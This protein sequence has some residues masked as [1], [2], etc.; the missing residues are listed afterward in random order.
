MLRSSSSEDEDDN[1]REDFAGAYFGQYSGQTQNTTTPVPAPRNTYS[2]G[3]GSN[4]GYATKSDYSNSSGSPASTSRPPSFDNTKPMGGSSFDTVSIGSGLSVPQSNY[5]TKSH[6]GSIH[7]TPI[8]QYR[9]S[10]RSNSFRSDRGPQPIGRSASPTSSLMSEREREELIRINTE[11]ED[12]RRQL[13]IYVFVLRCIA[14][15]FNAK[16]KPPQATYKRHAK[17]SKQEHHRIKE[18]FRAFLKGEIEMLADDALRNAVQSYYEVFLKSDRVASM[19]KCGACS[20]NDFREV[21]KN[22]IE[23]RVRSLPAINGLSKETVLASW[24]T[25]FDAI[26]RGDEDESKR[27]QRSAAAANELILSK[28]QLYEMFQSIFDIKKYEHLILF[29]ALQLDNPDEQA[30]QVRRE[31]A[32]RQQQLDSHDF[33]TK[34]W[35]PQFLVKEMESM[36]ISELNSQI[37]TLK[38]N[39]ESV[40]VKAGGALPRRQKKGHHNHIDGVEESDLSLSKHDVVLSFTIEVVIQELRGLKLTGNKNVYCTMEVDGCDK[41]QT[42]LAPVSKPNWGT[43]GD[44]PTTQPLP[45]IKIKLYMENSGLLTI[46]DKELGKVTLKPTAT[47]SKNPQFYKLTTKNNTDD[48]HLRVAVRMDKPQNM[49]YCGYLYALGKRVWSTCKSRYFVLVQVSQCAFAV[50]RYKERKAEP[51][52]MLHLKGF[53]VDYCER[54]PEMDPNIP[55]AFNAVKEGDSV[56]FA[57][58]DENERHHW[59]QALYRATGQSHKPTPPTI[60]ANGTNTPNLPN[61]SKAQGEFERERN[62]G[63]DEFLSADPCNFNH[64]QLF[65]ILQRLTLEYRMNEA[66]TCLGWF[67]PGQ[68]YI[69]DEYVARYGVRGCHR[70]LC[71]TSD[72]LDQAENGLMIDPNIMHFAFAFSSAHVYGNKPDGLGTITTEERATFEVIRGRLQALLEH[73]IT[74]FRYSFPFGR[75]DG[76]LKATLSLL[77]KVLMKERSTQH[78]VDE[79]RTVI[80]KC[81]EEAALVNYTRI[82]EFA[83][84]EEGMAQDNLSERLEE[85]T[86]LAG[87]CIEVLQQNEEHHAEAFTWFDDVLIEHNEMFWSLFAVDMD[88][89]LEAQPPDSWDSFSLFSLL[90][91]YLL[92]EKNLKNGKF[93]HHLRETF[94]P[95]VVRYVDLMES[96]VAQSIDKGFSK[97]KWEPHGGGCATSEDMLWKLSALQ[98]FIKELQWPEEVFAEHLEH[99]L[100][101]MASDMIEAAGNRTTQAFDIMLAR[102]SKYLDFVIPS[103]L[104]VMINTLADCKSQALNLCIMSTGDA[105]HQ[106]HTRIEEFLEKALKHTMTSLIARLILVMENTFVKLK[107]FDEGS[108]L[109][110]LLSLTK[111]TDELG[112]EYVQ[113]LSA[114]LDMIRQKTGDEIFVNTIFEIWYSQQLHCLNKWLAERADL[115]LHPYQL[116]CVIHIIKKLYSY[117]E[118]Q[119]VP[120]ECLDSDVYRRV[121][122]R[123]NEEETSHSLLE[124]RNA[125]AVTN[126]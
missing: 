4:Y 102:A 11:Q 19:V 17:M 98:T 112:K 63:L 115:A 114:N 45:H 14:F 71:Y 30:A 87:L 20:E 78:S 9:S 124:S 90:N 36:Y 21:F 28:D 106:Y 119:G 116:T 60:A 125:R 8:K 12:R 40:P 73:Q 99:R 25:K 81:L 55:Y 79:V 62:P 95:Q 92:T 46:E 7:C 39:L 5:D 93:H 83:K 67:S 37:S 29:N 101:L 2:A 80:K 31:L 16:Q 41:L 6:D 53:T 104:C 113:F 88:A 68:N 103:E 72:L 22:N 65:Q 52:E 35:R 48:L 1:D 24:M 89:C 121:C 56:T 54:H 42:G 34:L 109:K 94:A 126:F 91:G 69:L 117:F 123:V 108:L 43:Q 64:A 3:S 122:G 100:K 32:S 27:M 84:I 97:E 75:P 10:S 85:M 118:L 59:V 66:Y 38:A 70:Y 13:Q 105:M 107:R 76:A 26:Y 74:H 96:S 49:K 77:E 86:H 61:V 33:K 111:P 57:T 15:P 110:S 47:N 50:C 58:A 51:I 23:K 18:R 120:P 44:F 82:S